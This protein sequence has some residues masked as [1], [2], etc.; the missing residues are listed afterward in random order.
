MATVSSFYTKTTVMLQDMRRRAQET[1]LPIMVSWQV[2]KN[3][4]T[5]RILNRFDSTVKNF[6]HLRPG[7]MYS[8]SI[9]D[10]HGFDRSWATRVDEEDGHSDMEV[11]ATPFLETYPGGLQRRGIA[12]VKSGDKAI[13]LEQTDTHVKVLVHDVIGWIQKEQRI[14]FKRITARMLRRSG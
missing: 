1:G 8:L 5:V 7:Q 9:H 10:G 12:R 13:F 14:R 2:H 11:H 6:D 4:P 3:K